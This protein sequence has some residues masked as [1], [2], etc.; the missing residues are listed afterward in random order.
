[1]STSKDKNSSYHHGDLRNALIE[2]GLHQLTEAGI[3]RLSL[4]KIARDVGVSHNA[5]Y[6]HF[7]DKEGLLAAM[8]LEGFTLLYDATNVFASNTDMSWHAQFSAVAHAY[9]DFALTHP[10]HM[11]VMFRDY[12]S[13]IYPDT[14]QSAER[15]FN[16]LRDVM[17]EGQQAGL[18]EAGDSAKQA[19]LIWS[20]LHG[21]AMIIAADK[22]PDSV[23]AEGESRQL[24]QLFIDQVYRGL[25][26]TP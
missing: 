22:M 6:M 2:A 19:A 1:M 18:I 26:V 3:E 10:A 21:L 7:K 20:L 17:A 24:I 11:Q 16:L 25:K 15:A 5:P 8:A 9:V 13:N 4:R 14:S 23:I 12:D